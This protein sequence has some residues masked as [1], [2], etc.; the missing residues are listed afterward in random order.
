MSALRGS[1]T[2]LDVARIRQGSL[3]LLAAGYGRPSADVTGSLVD[4]FDALLDLGVAD[5]AFAPALERWVESLAVADPV[6]VSV[7][8]VRLFGAGMD[9]AVCTPIESQH[10][11]SNLQGDPARHAGRIEDLMRRSGFSSLDAALPPDHLQTQLEL[12]SALC[13]GEAAARAAGELAD[14]WLGWQAEIVVVLRSWV[15]SFAA[16]VGERDRVGV[17]RNLTLATADFIE[18]DHDLVRTLMAVGDDPE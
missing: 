6:E 15:G 12:A 10:L 17:L 18:H 13:G 4:G 11:G 7:E 8:H 5:F 16:E 3:R 1:E 9:G 2:G 14:R